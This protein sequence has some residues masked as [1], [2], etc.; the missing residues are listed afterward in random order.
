LALDEFIRQVVEGVVIEVKLPFERPVG[1][2]STTL[3]HLDG[4]VQD[5]VEV[6]DGL[7]AKTEAADRATAALTILCRRD[8]M[9]ALALSDNRPH[10]VGRDRD[11]KL[12]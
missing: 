8:L 3:E 6:H 11:H 2:A 9:V 12:D 1:Q 7:S 5:V 10:R 4:L